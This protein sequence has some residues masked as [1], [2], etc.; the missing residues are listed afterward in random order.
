MDSIIGLKTAERMD[1]HEFSVKR[2]Q[3]HEMRIE[4][5]ECKK[6]NANMVKVLIDNAALVIK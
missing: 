3:D 2:V 1:I 6:N 5:T 4:L